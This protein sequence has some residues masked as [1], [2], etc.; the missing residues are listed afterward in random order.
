MGWRDDKFYYSIKVLKTI[1][2][3]YTS[4]YEGLEFRSGHLIVNPWS[5]AEFK[6]DFDVALLSIGKGRWT[7]NITRHKFK[8]Y[9][10]SG[11]LQRI[12]IADIFGIS[13]YELEGLGFYSIPRLRGY[14]YYLMVCSLNGI[15]KGNGKYYNEE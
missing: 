15:D 2:E 1:A 10:Y 6:A 4:L 14:A 13:D 7:G 12:I 5:L 3:N 11:R 9:H 8:D